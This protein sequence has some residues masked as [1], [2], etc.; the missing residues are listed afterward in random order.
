[1]ATKNN[2]HRLI[3]QKL[4]R[5]T[6]QVESLYVQ[7]GKKIDEHIIHRLGSITNVWRFVSSWLGLVVLLIAIVT[8]QIQ[9]LQN[10]Y[11]TKAFVPGGTYTEGILGDF[12]TSNPIYVDSPVDQAVSRLIFSGLFT[13][14]TQDQLIGDLAQSWSVDSTGKVYT[15]HL[16]PHLTWQDGQPLT[17]ADVVFTYKVIQNPNANSPLSESWQ[18]VQVAEINPE[19]VTFTLSNP[20]VSFPYSLTN[21]IIPQHLLASIPL[22]D[23]RSAN[24]N[25]DPIGAGPFTWKSLEVEGNTPQTR[26]EQITME[27]FNHYVGGKPKLSDFVL[28]AFHDQGELIDNFQDG[29][30]NGVAGLDEVP[31][32]LKNDK[33]LNIYNMPLT[34]ANMV[35]FKTSSGVLSDVNVRQALVKAA[36]VNQIINGLG[37]PAIPV[38]EPLLSNQLG[39]NSADEQF[40]TNIIAANQQLTSDGWIMGSGGIRYKNS[41]PLTFNLFSSNDPD[42]AYVTSALAKQWRAIGVNVQIILQDD[43]DLQATVAYGNYDAVLYGISIGVDPD[44]FVYWDS[45]QTQ[46]STGIPLNLSDYRSAAADQALE[47]GRT[48]S[49]P[50]LRVAIYQSFL[51]TWQQDAPALGLYQPRFLYLTNE[52]VGGISDRLIND[53]TDRFDNV[54]DWEV[55]Q[56]KVKD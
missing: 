47:A 31:A 46:G 16:K 51:Q 12:T 14:N 20:L 25:I 2:S 49:D 45:S 26:Q 56:A 42:F 22:I 30:L 13:Y 38:R 41:Q 10:Y 7:T 55:L 29:A 53:Q 9:L 40:S 27:P 54:Q 28:R 44:V 50:A 35:F 4:R 17:A 52:P 43:S 11:T 24:F 33:K 5:G 21:G 39:F 3:R 23:L 37:Y 48:R 1:M 18:N 19:T 15:V 36:N 8:V 6:R 32:S 34:A